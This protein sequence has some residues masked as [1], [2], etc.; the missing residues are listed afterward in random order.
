MTNTLSKNQFHIQLSFAPLPNKLQ[1]NKKKEL[2]LL[3]GLLGQ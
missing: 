2:N 3:P 1:K